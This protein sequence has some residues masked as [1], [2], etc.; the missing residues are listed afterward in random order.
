MNPNDEDQ[1]TAVPRAIGAK[2]A[3]EAR[4]P[5]GICVKLSVFSVSAP[6]FLESRGTE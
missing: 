2:Q 5:L 6:T 3:G 4:A 1:P